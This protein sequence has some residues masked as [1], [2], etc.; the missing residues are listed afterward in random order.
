[1]R[2]DRLIESKT[3]IP[4]I[5]YSYVKREAL[6]RK[7][8]DSSDGTKAVV[9]N[10]GAG[11]GKTML[12]SFYATQE[13][14]R[15]C[16]WYSL[17]AMDND[18][19]TFIGYLTCA[20]QRTIPEFQFDVKEEYQEGE[21]PTAISLSYD[22]AV[23]LMNTSMDNLSI[24]LD[25][26][27][28]I[29]N[30]ELF[31]FISGLLNNT[32]DKIKFLIATKA[33]FPGF[34]LRYFYNGN[35]KVIYQDE[36]AFSSEEIRELVEKFLNVTDIRE[37]T[38]IMEAYTEGWPAGVTS[39]LLRMKQ[40]RNNIGGEEMKAL[41]EECPADDYLM[42]EIFRKLPYD[43]Q[44]FLVNTSI[45]T[46]LS[47]DIC[48][49]V[50][51]I[52]KAKST[53][54]YLVKENVFVLKMSGR[55]DTYRYHSIFRSYLQKQMVLEQKVKICKKACLWCL[56]NE[57]NE[58]AVDYAIESCDFEL[59]QLSLNRIGAQMV[60]QHKISSLN[61]WLKYLNWHQEEWNVSTTLLA[62]QIY[63]LRGEA[64]KG[65]ELIGAA[66]DKARLQGEK[67]ELESVRAIRE[68][69]D[70]REQVSCRESGAGKERREEERRLVVNCFGEFQVK[71]EGTDTLIF[72][73]TKKAK[74]LF[75][76]LYDKHGEEVSKDAVEEALWPE[77]DPNSISTLFY[78]TA[79]Y[80]RKALANVGY[81][82]VIL[83]KNRMYSMDMK[84]ILTPQKKL[85]EITGEDLRE[86]PVSD[87]Y[88]GAYLDSVQSDWVIGKREYY[89]RRYMQL[90]CIQANTMINAERYED[91]I[92]ILSG[93]M[94]VDGYAEQ[95]SAMLIRCYGMVGDLRNARRQFERT[96]KLLREELGVDVGEDMRL[97]YQ[98]AVRFKKRNGGAK[99]GE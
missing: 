83:Q 12:L 21:T 41:C 61:Q 73:R 16:A 39:I 87:I 92:R 22:F 2:R 81:E 47:A 48:N 9:L 45:L 63:F 59:V 49:A 53:L 90:S 20:I 25:D 5:L 72:W 98:E 36:L 65:K 64:D 62:A 32:S 70:S 74:E 69:Y 42:Y 68:L 78:T 57:K 51:G 66:E 91:A 40:Y 82:D 18:L 44:N 67:Q 94:A 14:N 8:C 84:R 50:L 75:A 33:A 46:V 58:Q 27:Q 52:D 29:S 23:A 95:L 86:E 85:D 7:I 3:L 34:L 1:M 55:G 96:E 4:R 54:D 37:C 13:Q 38:E 31:A 26:F 19:A 97:A 43:M 56:S 71:I 6:Y 93:A 99:N 89:E 28:E 24:I 79:S 35:V 80:V 77:T 30:E 17:D 11:F 76:F 10:A 15:R 88:K 60:A